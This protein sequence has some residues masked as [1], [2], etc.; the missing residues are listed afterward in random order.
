MNAG[1]VHSS[2][3]H[4]VREYLTE[5][6]QTGGVITRVELHP[7]VKGK[8]VDAFFTVQVK[9]ASGKSKGV[10]T[11]FP[12]R[13]LKLNIYDE[14]SEKTL[15]ISARGGQLKYSA[16]FEYASV[17]EAPYYLFISPSDAGRF[18]SLVQH[19]MYASLLSTMVVKDSLVVIFRDRPL[20]VHHK[21]GCFI[22]IDHRDPLMGLA[23]LLRQEGCAELFSLDQDGRGVATP[24]SAYGV[25]MLESHLFKTCSELMTFI[26][27]TKAVDTTAF[28][29]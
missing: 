21:D 19:P 23:L 2:F 17:L 15:S 22:Q 24:I 28:Y 20:R 4:M 18:E 25:S 13:V 27:K 16:G 8:G 7:S 26:S 9:A 11:R 3:P 5:D 29:F 6:F 10:I 14:F 12:Q 1:M